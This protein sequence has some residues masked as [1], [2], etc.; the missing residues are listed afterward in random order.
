I[1]KIPVAGDTGG[2]A[3]IFITGINAPDGIAI[4]RDDNLWVCAN[5]EDEIVVIDT[6]GKVI[7]KLGDFDGID[8]KGFPRGLL[9][10]A[11]L[12]FSNARSPLYAS[13]RP[14]FLPKGGAQP[15]I[16]WAGP[17]EFSG[18]PVSKLHAKTPPFSGD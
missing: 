11:S 10:P 12:A 17:L 5:Q 7:A 6:T 14:L 4:D 18:P 13:N 8:P 2:Q 9:F 3:S 1:I 15:A 16:A